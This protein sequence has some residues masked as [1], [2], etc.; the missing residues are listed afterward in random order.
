[1]KDGFYVPYQRAGEVTVDAVEKAGSKYVEL[2]AENT[3]DPQESVT[4]WFTPTE[5]R[6][7]AA[8]L[9]RLADECEGK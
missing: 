1:M 6:E 2:F 3:S 8:D 9:L 5:A 7:L 4:H